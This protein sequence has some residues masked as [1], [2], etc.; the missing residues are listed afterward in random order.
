MKMLVLLTGPMLVG[1]T[2][3]FVLRRSRR[4]NMPDGRET[5]SRMTPALAVSLV[6]SAVII[7]ACIPLLLRR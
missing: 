2:V 6:I 1:L 3:L 7:A 4:Q 5:V